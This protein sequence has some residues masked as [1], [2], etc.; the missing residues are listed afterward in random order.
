MD[1]VFKMFRE[2]LFQNP[3]IWE[4]EK[5]KTIFF[6]VNYSLPIRG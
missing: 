4:E 6:K 1:L 5:E 2:F 3:L